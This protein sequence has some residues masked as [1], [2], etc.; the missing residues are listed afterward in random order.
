MTCRSPVIAPAINEYYDGHQERVV[1]AAIHHGEQLAAN[2]FFMRG[3]KSL[4][5]F[6]GAR[7]VG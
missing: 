1:V 3:W 2:Y 6:S 5:D 7:V 4:A